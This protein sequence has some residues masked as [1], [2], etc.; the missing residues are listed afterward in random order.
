MLFG[1]LHDT[2]SPEA[3]QITSLTD[4]DTPPH[5]KQRL[6]SYIIDTNKTTKDVGY[7]WLNKDEIR[8]RNY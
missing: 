3:L 1:H 8:Q 4:G 6:D 7:P 5:L 2:V